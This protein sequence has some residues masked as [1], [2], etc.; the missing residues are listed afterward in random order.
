[1]AIS[2]RMILTAPLAAATRAQTAGLPRQVKAF[3]IDF[4]WLKGAFAPPGHW[5]DASPEEH[6]DWYQA[7]GANTIQ[8]FCVSCNGYAW[9]RGGVVPPQPGLRHD[10]LADVVRLG[11]RRGMLV[12]GYFCIGANTRWAREHPAESYGAP[13]NVYHL[14][15]TDVYL[16]YLGDAIADAIRRTGIDGA[17]IDWVWNPAAK[18][19]AQGWI[20]AEQKLYTQLTGRPFPSSGAPAPDDQ[21]A[22][23]RRA[24]ERCWERIRQARDRANPR[25]I[26]WLACARLNDPTVAGSSLLRECNWVMNEAP[27]RDLLE[28]ARPMVGAKTRLIQNVAGWVNHDAR[29]FLDHPANRSLD[30]YGFA[31]PR[32]TSLPL[33]VSEYLARPLSSFAGTDR[34]GANDR[35]IA[36]LARFYRGLGWD[37]VIP[38]RS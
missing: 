8:T 35:N 20:P 10:F 18:L 15:L 7:L 13:S 34:M 16:D 27:S 29:A 36:A 25:C 5:A 32:E 11:H 22:Y 9:Y 4:N 37:A 33:P 19:R 3:C 24:I 23:E 14:P 30:L 21:L 1:M 31:E 17:M 2:R 12:F 38:R 28:A 26:L 6:A